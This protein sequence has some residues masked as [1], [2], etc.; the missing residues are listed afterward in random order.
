[1]RYSKRKNC[2]NRLKTARCRSTSQEVWFFC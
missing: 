1:L 2:S